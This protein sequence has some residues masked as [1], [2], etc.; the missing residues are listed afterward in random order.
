MNR[1]NG[2]SVDRPRIGAITVYQD[3]TIRKIIFFR[4]SLSSLYENKNK[5]KTIL[6]VC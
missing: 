6:N 4:T 1:E 5:L 3:Y 2:L